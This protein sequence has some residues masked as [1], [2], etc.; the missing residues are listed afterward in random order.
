MANTILRLSC[1]SIGTT[2]SN[3]PN[4]SLGGNMGT[5]SNAIITTAN[6]TLNNLFDNISKLENGNGTTDYRC[7]F[8]H[9]DT[10][11]Q[12]EV[13]ANGVLFLQGSPKATVEVGVGPKGTVDEIIAS[14][15]TAPVGITFTQPTEGAP[16][17]MSGDDILNPGEAIPL[18]IKR[19]ANNVAGAGTITDI[20]SLVVRGIE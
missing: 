14:E 15:T 6:T 10:V 13:F 5:D 9:N 1:G 17:Q 2:T 18:W 7:V 19:T 12:G 20:I 8:I 11:V 4:N 3:G 16:L